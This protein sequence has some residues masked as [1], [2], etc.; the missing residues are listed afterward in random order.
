MQ[1]AGHM[2]DSQLDA[3]RK[4]WEQVLVL[5]LSGCTRCSGIMACSRDMYIYIPVSL[6]PIVNIIHRRA[7]GASI[8]DSQ[9][10][11]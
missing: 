6:P 10:T 11:R 8:V 5:G 7:R 4:I 9:R 2:Y 1:M 3:F